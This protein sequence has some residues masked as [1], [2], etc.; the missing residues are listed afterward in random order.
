MK[1]RIGLFLKIVIY[2]LFISILTGCWSRHELDEFSI[3]AGMGIDKS[4]EDGEIQLT[5]QIVKPRAL[6]PGEGS[7]S[8]EDAYFNIESTGDTVFTAVREFTHGATRK[9]YFPHNQ[10]IIFSRNTAEEGVQKYIDFFV[11]DPE[12]RLTVWILVAKDKAD[13]LLEIKSELELIPALEISDLV[14]AQKATSQSSIVKLQHFITRLLSKTTSPVA[15]LIEVS[16][17]E[18]KA[19]V[20]GTAVFKKDKLTGE[21][22]KTETRGLL[23]VIGEIKSGIIDVDCPG[24]GKASL[25]IIRASS[26]ITPKIKDGRIHMK[27]EI[28]EEGNL[29][30]QSCL[31]DL[32]LPPKVDFLEKEKEAVIRSE[33]MAALKK[34]RKLNTD[35]FGFGEAV[36][37]KYRKEWKELEDRWDEVFPNIEVEVIVEA[38]LRRTGRITRPAST[39]KE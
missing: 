23:W 37:Q 3:V 21:L 22:D 32:T 13:E 7:S 19:F 1:N 25:E 36:H 14:E 38:K 9:L 18:K 11:R 10:V 26:K 31:E 20:S 34:A 24:G 30:S 15:P 2:M 27:I 39:E 29:G 6:K 16:G 8:P 28:K 35:I 17:K 5:A 33:V 4:E 12:T